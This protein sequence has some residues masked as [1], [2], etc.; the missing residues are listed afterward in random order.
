MSNPEMPKASCHRIAGLKSA[1]IPRAVPHDFKETRMAVSATILTGES[2][3]STPGGRLYVISDENPGNTPAVDAST[4]K[5]KL[6]KVISFH[7]AL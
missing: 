1:R 3:P 5:L 4:R 2:G 6:V 7:L